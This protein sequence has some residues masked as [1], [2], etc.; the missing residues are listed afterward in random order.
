MQVNVRMM[1]EESCVCVAQ[2]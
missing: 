2:K 1:M